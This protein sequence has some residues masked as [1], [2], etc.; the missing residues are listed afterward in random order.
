MRL[1]DADAL[2]KELRVANK[3][4][5]DEIIKCCIGVVQTQPTAYNP[6]A[7]IEE[8]QD[9]AHK[10]YGEISTVRVVSIVRKGGVE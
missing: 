3:E 1:I 9:Y 6:N 10:C 8:I 5:N 4:A 7:V 2:V